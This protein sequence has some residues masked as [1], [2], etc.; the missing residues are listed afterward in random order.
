MKYSVIIKMVNN[1]EGINV[2]KLKVLLF[3]LTIVFLSVQNVG[4]QVTS[5]IIIAQS[6]SDDEDNKNIR[7]YPS[8]KS[9]KLGSTVKY[10]SYILVDENGYSGI[11][12]DKACETDWYKIYFDGT[13]EGYICGEKTEII[14]S[15][16]TDDVAPVTA[17]EV[18]MNNLGFPSSYWGG[19]CRLK[20]KYPLW[21]FQALQVDLS[22]PDVVQNES[23]CGKSKIES[24]HLPN[25]MLDDTCTNDNTGSFV[26]PKPVIVAYYMDPRNFLSEGFLFQFL[27]LGYYDL[28][29]NTYLDAS[30]NILQGTE[31]YK[32]HLGNGIDLTQKINE[33]GKEL[34]VSPIFTSARILQELGSGT[35]L[36]NLYS[37]TGVAVLPIL[38]DGVMVDTPVTGYYNFYNIGVSDSCVKES[39][40]TYCGIKYAYTKGWNTVSL[41]IKGG[42]EFI[43]K[44]YMQKGQDTVYLQKFNVN[45]TNPSQ[46]Y[47]HQYMQNIAAPSSESVISFKSYHNLNLLDSSLIFSIPVYKNMNETIDNSNSG[48]E[49]DG[50]LDVPKPSSIPIHTIVTSS[51]FKYTST[52]IAGIAPGT[53]VVSLKS[54]L[55]SVGG[56]STVVITDLNGN[57]VIEG[58]L[59][60]GFKVSIN[61]Q[62]TTEVLNVV[63]KGDTSGDGVVNALDLLQVQ[64]NILGTYNFN[65]ASLMAADPS[66]DGV[67]N[68]LD[69]LQIQKHILG[70][71]TIEQ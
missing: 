9:K 34:N 54:A 44:N 6:M 25:G 24:T 60:T 32:Y 30:K 20:E 65:E 21:Q 12:G 70:T 3:L 46:L 35:S 71:Y 68:A 48:A 59:G 52:S 37:G 33:V 40:T 27:H 49:D 47:G 36:Y 17:C 29:N 53:S 39:G 13:K 11:N 64:K 45:P 26:T 55:E 10:G 5:R 23:A 14:K 4:A 15:H 19:L 66:G 67:V 28:F 8:S 2:R 56:N 69:L 43:A 16:S 18:E 57:Q 7:E 41:G 42:V 38:V 1:K 58:V 22:W 51:G 31:V 62:S 50:E 63:V 61:N